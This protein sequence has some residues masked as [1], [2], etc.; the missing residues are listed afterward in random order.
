MRETTLEQ[1]KSQNEPDK[2]EQ[3]TE[4]PQHFNYQ[5]SSL[6]AEKKGERL[7]MITLKA[8]R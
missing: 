7:V 6:E 2:N 1:D 8:I 4:Y 3:P 5:S